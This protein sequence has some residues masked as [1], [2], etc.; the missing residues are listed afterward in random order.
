MMVSV[1]ANIAA[2]EY[3]CPENPSWAFEAVYVDEVDM[4]NCF[5]W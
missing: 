5:S 2:H 3:T 4:E 1:L